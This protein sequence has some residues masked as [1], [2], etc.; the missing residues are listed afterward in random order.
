MSAFRKGKKLTICLICALILSVITFSCLFISGLYLNRPAD[1][2]VQDIRNQ[3]INNYKTVWDIHN[4]EEFPIAEGDGSSTNPFKCS[5]K[6]G[7]EIASV[8]AKEIFEK[9]HSS[10][11][12]DPSVGVP[13][14]GWYSNIELT[15][16]ID[17]GEYYMSSNDCIADPIR[18]SE[19]VAPHIIEVSLDY[20]T[21]F[22]G[23]EHTIKN[24]EVQTANITR[25]EISDN[26]SGFFISASSKTT[27]Q[28]LRIQNLKDSSCSILANKCGGV[29]GLVGLAEGCTISNCMVDNFN[30]EIIG[31]THTNVVVG[32]I[33][34]VGWANVENAG[35]LNVKV[36]GCCFAF[37]G[38]GPAGDFTGKVSSDGTKLYP[39]YVWDSTTGSKSSTYT[40]CLAPNDIGNQIGCCEHKFA[41]SSEHAFMAMPK[42]DQAAGMVYPNFY[43][44][45]IQGC[46]VDQSS[47]NFSNPAFWHIPVLNND[48]Y[49]FNYGWPYLKMFLNIYE[50]E[51]K[52][53]DYGNVELEPDSTIFAVD[54]YTIEIPDSVVSEESIL[55]QLEELERN[56]TNTCY[57]KTYILYGY[58]VKVSVD[59][60][61]G[62][63][64]NG[65]E[66]SISGN[67]KTIRY[68]AKYK[69]EEYQPNIITLDPEGNEIGRYMTEYK[70]VYGD[71]CIV[72]SNYNEN[73][74]EICINEDV[75]LETDNKWFCLKFK[76]GDTVVEKGNVIEITDFGNNNQ[77][78]DL[79]IYLDLKSY[80]VEVN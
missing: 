31:D 13:S 48:N 47:P 79:Y 67:S 64:F 12:T 62:H 17:L 72:S 2:S 4:N 80:N 11:F 35:I 14:E 24:V 32:G 74:L 65:F 10:F 50:F 1:A 57:E 61:C 71:N 60:N 53:G 6:K 15:K 44:H 41:I 55:N 28:N 78:I 5:S 56:I 37:A 27:I 43:S 26:F 33:F 54:G 16:D 68:T 51:F 18:Y 49:I 45:T 66:K 7:L 63:V 52:D 59:D 70:F 29:G 69:K 77:V 40:N 42:N 36:N 73:H 21:N 8:L 75:I 76:I 20:I 46:T 34:A 30:V 38:I 3:V 39:H 9:C 23:A 58:K 19:I 22:D 25:G